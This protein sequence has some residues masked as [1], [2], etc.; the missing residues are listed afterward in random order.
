MEKSLNKNQGGFLKSVFILSLGGFI[1]K[2]LGAFYRIPLTNIIGSYG[3][4]IYQLVFPLFSLLLTISTAGIPV[5]VSKLV[6][7]KAAVGQHKQAHKV[8]N[9]ALVMLATFGL[10]GSA[11]LFFLSNNIAALQGNGDAA[12]AYKIIAP[13]VFLVCIISAY[14]GYFQGLMQ[15]S[16][17]AVSQIVEQVVKMTVGLVCAIKFMPDVIKSVNFAILGVTLSEVAATV[18]LFVMY[19]F[20]K[21]KKTDDV[22]NLQPFDRKKTDRKSVV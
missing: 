17:T 20:Q 5:A 19:L 7:E 4:G 6:A 10:I 12:T 22:G 14:R 18:L 8:F 3:M 9:T 2:L 16:P 21:R 15:M 13:S 11:L 1:A